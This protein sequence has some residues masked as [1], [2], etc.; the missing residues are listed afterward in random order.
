MAEAGLTARYIDAPYY[1][2]ETAAASAISYLR[3]NPNVTAIFCANDLL[4]ISFMLAA[5]QVG[6]SVPDQVS[7]IGFDDIDL[8]SFVSPALTTM[9]VDKAGMGR[10]AVTLLAHRLDVGK[11]CVTVTLVRP[12]LVERETV[13]T[14]EPSL[15]FAETTTMLRTE[16]QPVET[17]PA[18]TRRGSR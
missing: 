5:R 14:L 9:A 10:L 15:R 16:A 11:E 12:Q 18:G 2:H 13:L 17:V 6:I 8:A 7:L 4:A 1:E 3:A